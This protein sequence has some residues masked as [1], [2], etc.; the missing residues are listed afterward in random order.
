MGTGYPRSF[1]MPLC[2]PAGTPPVMGWAR[3]Q[4]LRAWLP[5]GPAAGAGVAV[6]TS[7]DPRRRRRNRRRTITVRPSQT[8]ATPK[9]RTSDGIASMVKLRRGTAG[10]RYLFSRL[11]ATRPAGTSVRTAQ[12]VHTPAGGRALRQC[13]A[14]TRR[15]LRR[16]LRC[17]VPAAPRLEKGGSLRSPPLSVPAPAVALSIQGA[18]A[19]HLEVQ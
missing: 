16:N 5:A 7:D 1:L 17:A 14:K 4:C 3:R 19:H 12:G 10:G 13:W 8:K 6:A 15:I 2:R 11:E 18:A 9:T